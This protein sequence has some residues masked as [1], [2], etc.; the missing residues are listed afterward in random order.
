MKTSLGK[1]LTL[2]AACLLPFSALAQVNSGSE[3]HDGALN[4]KAIA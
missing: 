2:L 4:P 1:L 3:G